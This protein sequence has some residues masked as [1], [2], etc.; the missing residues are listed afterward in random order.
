VFGLIAVLIAGL[1]G[2]VLIAG[3]IYLI[4]KHGLVDAV[5]DSF[6]N[7]VPFIQQA[8][9]LTIALVFGLCGASLLTPRK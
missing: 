9:F 8:V 1:S 5:E 3:W 4:R 2:S 7:C 6:S